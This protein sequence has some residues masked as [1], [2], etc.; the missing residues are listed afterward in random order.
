M[1]EIQAGYARHVAMVYGKFNNAI[2]QESNTE[3]A[4]FFMNLITFGFRTRCI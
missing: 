2:S 3:M 4:S 1:H